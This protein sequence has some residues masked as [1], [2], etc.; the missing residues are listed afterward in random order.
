MV[1]M[2]KSKL[3]FG[4]YL[5]I[6]GLLYLGITA[7]GQDNFPQRIISLGPSMTEELYLLGV[8]DRLIGCTL[9]CKRPK[10]AE[11]KEKVATAIDVNLEKLIMLQPDL[12]L[13]T[14]LTDPKSIR[15]LKNLGIKVVRFPE[16][17]NFSQIC[18]QFLELARLVGEEKKA[19]EIVESV[20]KRVSSIKREVASLNRLKVFVQIG[21]RPLFTATKHSFLNDLIELAGG[22]NIAK[23][24]EV[25]HYSREQVLKSNPD[26]I[27]IVTM[28]IVGEQ[29]KKIWQ[30]FETLNAVRFNR[31]HILDSHEF[32]S[33]TP[34]SFVENLEEI[35][36]ILYP[37]RTKETR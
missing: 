15:K 26:V 28:G 9:Y 5:C 29:E 17:E 6:F 10:E 8:D 25:G 16:A 12:V 1:R 35:A 31:I 37:M 33:P 22:I 14:S 18:R 13:A 3:L 19:E 36:H 11:L 27:I 20:R 21:A 2:R 23:D 34:L 30:D 24:V 32:C 7:Y 4:V